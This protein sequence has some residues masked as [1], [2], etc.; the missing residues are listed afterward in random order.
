MQN[1]SLLLV[2][3]VVTSTAA[4][5]STPTTAA[6]PAPA[7]AGP[8]FAASDTL[9]DSLGYNDAFALYEVRI[10]GEPISEEQQVIRWQEELKA[11]RARAGALVGSYLSY[12]ALTASDCATAR[13]ALVR[14]DELGSDQASWLMAEL[15]QNRS[16]GTPERAQIERWLKKAVTLDYFAAALQL[17]ELY[18]PGDASG[19]PVQRYTYARVAGGYAEAIS[20]NNASAQPRPGYDAAALQAMEKDLSA[21]D[22]ARATSEAT[23]ILEQMLKRHQRFMHVQ[24]VEF[25]RGSAGGKA[26]HEYVASTLDYRHECQWNLRGNCAGTQRLISIEFTSKSAEFLSCKIDLKGRAFGGT[27][28]ANLVR[29]FLVG[30]KAKRT[31]AL[32]DVN[33]QPDK[34][35]LT[36]TCVPLPNLAANAAAGKCRAKLKGSIDVENFYPP[37]ARNSGTEGSA[38]VRYFVP[39]GSDVA[40]DAEIATS[41]GSAALDDAALATIRSGKFTNECAYGLSTIRIAFKLSN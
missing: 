28:E 19:D 37:S 3:A 13:D 6:P 9:P 31:L 21:A 27:A 14:A 17:I 5:Q 36:V 33:D 16:C 2:A 18:A 41:S 20:E 35:T 11:G 1:L 12:R 26:G 32:G 15:A 23:K 4:A 30:P 29:E 8:S 40:S 7:S 38:V 24:P 25:T 34:K 22:R 10:G 39:P